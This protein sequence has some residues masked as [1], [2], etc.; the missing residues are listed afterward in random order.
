MFY[1]TANNDHGLPHNPFKAIVAPRP[2]GWISTADRE[3]RTNLAPYSFF[4]AVCDRPPMVMFSSSGRK[5]S[6]KNIEATG[7]F[8]CNLA[9][10]DLR[11]QMNRS[12]ADF[13]HGI[14]EFSEAGL[15]AAPSRLVK[16]PRVAE[17]L[18][19]LECRCLQVIRPVDIHGRAADNWIVL[20]QVVGV[21]IDERAIVD[22]RFDVTFAR[23]LSRLGYMDYAVVDAVFP[24]VRPKA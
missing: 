13:E 9:S 3:G 1:E 10:Y 24:M 12:S 14:S 15:A 8:V 17:A 20:G 23:P 16:P 21:H 18:A 11:E 22:G 4:N 19:A 2:I 5:D 6:L 7:E